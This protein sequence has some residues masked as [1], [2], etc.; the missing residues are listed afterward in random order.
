MGAGN[1]KRLILN[2]KAYIEAFLKIQT[3]AGKIEPFRLNEPQKRLYGIVREQW[4]AG[5]PVRI[6]ILKARQ[7]AFPR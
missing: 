1:W 4:K 7:M 2:G 6:V 3:K 5:K